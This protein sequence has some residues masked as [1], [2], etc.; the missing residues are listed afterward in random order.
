MLPV[1]LSSIAVGVVCICGQLRRKR[2]SRDAYDK[3]YIVHYLRR[4]RCSERSSP[5]MPYK[6]HPPPPLPLSPPPPLPQTHP[7]PLP[8]RE[9]PPL[10]SA[11][12]PPLPLGYP[13]PLPHK[14]PNHYL[15]PARPSPLASPS[16][17]NPPPST[18]SP[19]CTPPH[20]PFSDEA[21]GLQSEDQEY[22]RLSVI[23]NTLE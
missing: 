12:P 21:S 15:S 1:V 23:L 4:R 7:P 19:A 11:Y 13:P 9:P 3:K 8:L 10:P 17:P 20:P 5:S 14:N 2:K 6:D 16:S 18:F 22:E